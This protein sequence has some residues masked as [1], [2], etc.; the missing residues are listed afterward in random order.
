MDVQVKMAITA[1]NGDVHEHS[2]A[3]LKKGRECAGDIGLST[4]ESDL[5]PKTSAKT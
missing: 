4:A 3:T 5:R 2:I 1:P